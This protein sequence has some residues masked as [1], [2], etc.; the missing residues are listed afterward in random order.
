MAI[1]AAMSRKATPLLIGT[2]IHALVT[3]VKAEFAEVKYGGEKEPMIKSWLDNEVTMSIRTALTVLGVL[4]LMVTATFYIYYKPCTTAPCEGEESR[5][6]HSATEEFGEQG[7][8]TEPQQQE[9]QPRQEEQHYEEQVESDEVKIAKLMKLKQEELKQ[10]CATR[11]LAIGGNKTE[12]A[13]RL[14][15]APE[16]LKPTA[17]QLTYIA[18]LEKKKGIATN[19]DA[20]LCRGIASRWIEELAP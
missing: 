5:G 7:I 10:A 8:N 11:G 17:K 15:A 6:P 4:V 20:Q 12:L 18:R 16:V 3:G 9:Q 2:I 14:L 19:P 13:Q 1:L